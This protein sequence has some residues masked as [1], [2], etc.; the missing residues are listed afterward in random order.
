MGDDRRIGRWLNGVSW[1]FYGVTLLVGLGLIARAL[2]GPSRAPAWLDAGLGAITRSL[3]S[4][5]GA[6]SWLAMGDGLL[7]A[8]GLMLALGS[9]LLLI[10]KGRRARQGRPRVAGVRLPYSLRANAS[11]GEQLG[12]MLLTALFFGACVALC[13]LSLVSEA[14]PITLLHRAVALLC[15]LACAYL[16]GLSLLRAARQAWLVGSG[17]EV[18]VECS[19]E[20]LAPGEAGTALV[21]Y[22]GPALEEILVTLVCRRQRARFTDQLVTAELDRAQGAA[23][24]AG[25]WEQSVSFVLPPD[26]EET[27]ERHQGWIEWSIEVRTVG[28]RVGAASVDFPLVVRR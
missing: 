12:E 3:F 9:S 15:G 26:A 28:P 10:E 2:L 24:G 27:G 19:H 14:A 11:Y 17:A 4:P 21:V 23:A 6:P 20:R 16:A 1:V 25:S 22:R 5:A 7:L 18:T 13:G 8:V